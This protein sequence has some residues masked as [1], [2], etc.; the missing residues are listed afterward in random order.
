MSLKTQ[1][2]IFLLFLLLSTSIHAQELLCTVTVDA[3]RIQSD[4]SVFEDMQKNISEYMN[5]T[6]WGGD[7][8]ESSERIR[9]NLQIV[10]T[11][12]PAPDYFVC[13]MNLQVFRPTYNSTYET[14]LLKIADRSFNFNYV[15]YQNMVF[16][17]N[18]YTDNLTALLNFYAY[19]ILAF[20]YDSFGQNSGG[21]FFQKSQ[22]IVNL[23][24]SASNESGWR[25]NED[26]RNRYWL[27]E[28]LSNSRY[29]SF[30]DILYKYHRQGLDMME[31]KPAQGRRAIME[32][33]KELKRL[34]QQNPLL[35]LI[36]TF[37][38]AKQNE[39]I[40]VFTKSFSND[41]QEFINIMQEIDPSNIARYNA[42]MDGK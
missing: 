23:A 40:G 14:I 31:S 3:G 21:P 5:F 38:D 12:R 25:A 28:N 9:C 13:N 24:S 8:F 41:K 33:L 22:E 27:M 18:T 42:V 37:L 32:T 2:F 36:K 15:A 34:N 20:D 29:K 16:T 7:K 35:I 30:H 17:D 39:L 19:L 26:Q 6:Q 4:R 1:P 10:V 11:Q